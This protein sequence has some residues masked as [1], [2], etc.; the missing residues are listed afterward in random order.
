MPEEI[1]VDTDKLREAIGE[2]MEKAEGGSLLREIAVT[3][4]VLAALAAIA[5]LQAGA[6]VNEALV[7]KT[8]ST[9]LQA[10]A[11]DQWAYYQAKGVKLSIQEAVKSLAQAA[12]R[13][14]PG[15]VDDQIKR[16]RTEQQDI[17]NHAKDLEKERDQRSEEADHLMHRHHGFA[18][19]VAMF[20]VAI[21][22][23]AIAALTRIRIVWLGS[24]A[25]GIGGLIF[26]LLPFV[27]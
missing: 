19:A 20:Q 4:A 27:Q 10:Q 12:G 18:N 5:A 22:L 25:I 7:L 9:K 15:G 17:Q 1:E 16:Y 24:I 6:T 11:S 3:T 23:G 14:V 8:E 26:F 21:A 13:P 2:E